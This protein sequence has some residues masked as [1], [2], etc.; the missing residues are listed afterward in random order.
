M[1]A[2]K[3]NQLMWQSIKA[4]NGWYLMEKAFANND[5]LKFGAKKQSFVMKLRGQK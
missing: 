2:K 5:Y 3:N 4:R 1:R